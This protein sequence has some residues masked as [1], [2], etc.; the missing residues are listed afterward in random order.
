MQIQ[1]IVREVFHRDL[2]E[3]LIRPLKKGMTNDSFYL[4]VDGKSYVLRK[5]G[6]GTEELIDRQG[7]AAAYQTI[8]PFQM[9]V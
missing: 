3:T 8:A 2:D 5:N 7:E 4:E 6:I 9:G 1:D